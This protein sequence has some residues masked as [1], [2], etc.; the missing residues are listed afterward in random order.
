MIEV[1]KIIIGIFSGLKGENSVTHTIAV[2]G[3]NVHRHCRQGGASSIF[4]KKSGICVVA[5]FGI[6]IFV[7]GALVSMDKFWR[8]ISPSVYFLFLDQHKWDKFLH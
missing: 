1:Q 8:T 4:L 7:V 3:R 5:S 6:L 2:L